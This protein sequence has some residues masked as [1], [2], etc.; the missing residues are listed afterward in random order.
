M[1]FLNPLFLVGTSLVALPIVLHLIMRRK[2]QYFEFP[3]LRFIQEQ[4]QSNRRRLRLR[5]LLLL[6]LRIAVIGL[7][8]FALARPSLKLSGSLVKQKAPVAAVLV[9]DTSK[10]MEYRHEN[11]TRLEVARQMGLDLLAGL[12][13]ESQ[14]AVFD[15]RLQ[16]GAFQVDAGAAENRIRRLSTTAAAQSLIGTLEE[17]LRLVAE[18]EL[19]QR[20]IY[21]FTDLAKAAWPED[22]SA[23]LQQQFAEASDVGAYLIDV[24]MDQPTNTALGELRLSGQV[25]S[26]RSPLRIETELFHDGQGTERS[27]EL[28][29][30]G[31]DR[32]PHKG[33][34]QT[35]TLEAGQSQ[36]IDFQIGGLKVGTH[37]GYVEIVGADGLAC[38]DRR[39]FTVQVKPAWQILLAAPS[40]ADRYAVFL[41]EALAPAS[42]RR[43]GQ[44]RFDCQVVAVDQLS[45][46]PLEDYS[47]VC[48]LDPT[49]LDPA[50][51]RKLGDYV[52]D[53][54]GLAVFLG[55]NAQKVDS[56]N[57]PTAQEVLSG[58]LLRQARRPD[59]DVYLAPD[60]FEHP[61]LASFRDLAGSVPWR[62]FP[63]F[64][65]WQLDKPAEGVDVVCSLTDGR[66]V[67]LER[68]LGNGRALTMTTPVS[69][70]PDQQAW[71]LLPVGESWPFLILANEMMS[72][73]VGATDQRLNY[74]AGQTAVLRLDPKT[75]YRSYVLTTL[76]SPD[77]VDVRLSPDLKDHLLM[78]TST[79]SLGNYRVRAG[80]SAG[81]VDRG[82]SVNLPREQTEL[83]RISEEGLEKVFGPQPHQVARSSDQLEIKVSEGR[84][85]RD[86]FP[87][88]IV[89]V[90]MALGIEHV[91]ANRFY[92][93]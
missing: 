48:L 68:P 31:A 24:G 40:P 87:I 50:T 57:Q 84:V 38:D 52:S 28:Y 91:L 64:R 62:D 34:Q 42:F 44:A 6:A 75:P 79:E 56:F 71:N 17:A 36:A 14:V 46:Q 4:H 55:R 39:F 18:S 29:L 1:T 80:G 93:D 35:T 7:L 72:Y 61:V 66:P 22:S 13:R 54:H 58:K 20:E 89:L 19:S 65:Y 92:R 12:P 77:A 49:P 23:R 53:G 69:D 78:V 3:A 10:R 90:A 82:F 59:G 25:L 11:R 5:H 88:L 37:Q 51:W 27:V 85:G 30:L 63:V 26:S 74:F 60:D 70:R 86:L 32:K 16:Q 41:A 9:F 43:T 83:E 2:P 47:A 67:I 15:T 45:K 8:A 76:D 81:G 73:L 21:V 33:G